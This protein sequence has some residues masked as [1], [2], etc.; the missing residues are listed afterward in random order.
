MISDT[1]H[2]IGGSKFY[3]RLTRMDAD[4]DKREESVDD[5]QNQRSYLPT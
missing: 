5:K 3:R 1:T 4:G 2:E